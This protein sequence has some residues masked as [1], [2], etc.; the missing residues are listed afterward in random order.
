MCVLFVLISSY[1]VPYCIYAFI[2]FRA[3]LHW[4]TPCSKM[5]LFFDDQLRY[6]TEQITQKERLNKFTAVLKY[7]CYNDMVL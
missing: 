2:S 1:D 3:T 4:S 7:C 5:W 6:I